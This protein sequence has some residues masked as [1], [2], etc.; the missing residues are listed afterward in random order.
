MRL[1]DKTI[2]VTGSRRGLGK[3]YAMALAREGANVV[4]SD[5]FTEGLYETAKEIESQ[6]ARSLAIMADVSAEGDAQN[7]ADETVKKFGK[8][9]VLVNN[10]A[11]FSSLKRR[12]FFEIPAE[13]WD[14]VL[15][16][17][18]RGVWLCCRAVFPYMRKQ[19]KGKIVNISSGTFFNGS[20]GMAHYVASKGGVIG[21]TRVLSK[22]LGQYNITA[23]SLAPGYTVTEGTLQMDS[24]EYRKRSIDSRT[25]KRDEV[26]SD[27]IG[28]MLFLCSD[29][30]DFMTGQTM[31][32]DGGR[33][34]H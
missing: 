33:I 9:D 23:N 22:E 20:P 26:P 17:N 24:D 1:K 18:L 34:L 15:S 30:S 7:L 10:A 3:A 32:V 16:V 6:G 19:S 31:V 12:P 28:A 21:L 14:R 4:V 27:L 8:I 13:E 2:I 25:L 5:V 29:D 11:Y